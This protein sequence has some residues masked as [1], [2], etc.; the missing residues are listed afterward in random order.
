MSE[1]DLSK[2]Q[3]V[4]RFPRQADQSL[5]PQAQTTNKGNKKQM[6]KKQNLHLKVDRVDTMTPGLATREIS[7]KQSDASPYSPP[8]GRGGPDSFS[9]AE[10]SSQL[11]NL[12]LV[13]Q[14]TQPRRHGIS[15]TS[16]HENADLS[17]LQSGLVSG[18]D[19]IID[20]PEFASA[21]ATASIMEQELQNFEDKSRQELELT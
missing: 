4:S 1:E 10:P 13:Q 6:K 18:R 2:P 19:A 3:L 9:I 15:G 12:Q 16:K 14:R 7:M 11:D 21:S 8:A 17:S 20:A 5:D